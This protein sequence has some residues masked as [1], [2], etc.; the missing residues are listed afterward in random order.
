MKIIEQFERYVQENKLFT[1]ADKLLVAVSGGRDSMLLLWI[2]QRAGYQV[3]IAHCNF[4]LRGEE[5]DADEALVCDFAKQNNIPF[6]AIRFDTD[7]YATQHKLSIQMAARELRYDWFA[8]LSEKLHCKYIAIAQHKNDHVETVLLNLTR[9]TGLL[10]LQG[11]LP[12]RAENNI[13]R[14][15]LFLDSKQILSLVEEYQIPYRDDASNFS[16]KYARNKIR[17]DI[18]PEFEQ[19]HADFVQ[20]MEENIIRFQET[21]TVLKEFVD[22]LRSQ[23][24]EVQSSGQIYIRK[25]AIRYLSLG[26]WYLLF[27]PYGFS[28]QV[29]QD[30]RT[31]I[32]RESGRIFQSS[33]HQLLLDREQLI[34]E[35]FSEE[36]LSK[37]IFEHQSLVTWNTNTIQLVVSEDVS[38]ETDAQIA[39]IDISKLVFPLQIRTWQEGDYFQPLGMKGKK[40]I[41]DYF[42]QKKINLFDKKSIPL[43]VN[44]NG[45]VIWI[46]GYHLDDRYKIIGNTQKVLKLVANK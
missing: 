29:L 8:K 41:S 4:Q 43:L 22:D 12:K 16:N 1:K 27:E 42:I 26:K 28:K 35:A 34:L 37:E 39:K 44:G 15:L 21:Y 13:V 24:F 17:L 40:K 18:I 31:A 19:L 32:D 7:D 38:I 33:S 23:L 30:L 10:G 45:D 20:T 11:I 46:V 6:H 3:E 9:G 5:S 14:P 25:E 2:L 36:C